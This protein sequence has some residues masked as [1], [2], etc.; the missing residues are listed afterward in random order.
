MGRCEPDRGLQVDPDS[1]PRGCGV[2]ARQG[3]LRRGK[4][5]AEASESQIGD[6]RWIRIHRPPVVALRRD[7]GR[8]GAGKRAPKHRNT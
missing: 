7:R 4:G 1:S 2:E 3:A 5:C 6:F 8:F